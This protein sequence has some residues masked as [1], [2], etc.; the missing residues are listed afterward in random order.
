M[1]DNG[2]DNI[3]HYFLHQGVLDVLSPVPDPIEGGI[4]V[5]EDGLQFSI[6]LLVSTAASVNPR[7]LAI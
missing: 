7:S 6:P 5:T 1:I 3:H 2:L 4:T